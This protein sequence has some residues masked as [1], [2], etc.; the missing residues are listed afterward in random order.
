M[1]AQRPEDCDIQL[2]EAMNRGDLDAAVA[3]YEPDAV[4]V[5]DPSSDPLVGHAAI[6]E[7]L[8]AAIGLGLQMT[9]DTHALRN[10][11]VALTGGRWRTTG[12]DAESKAVVFAGNSREVVRRQP[13]GT[14]RFVIDNPWGAGVD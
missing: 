4:L 8:R 14:W 3:L 5:P 12:T 10:G 1:S 6:R 13:D 2:M 9:R 11:D 7:Y